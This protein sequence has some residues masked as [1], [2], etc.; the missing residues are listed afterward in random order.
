MA[1]ESR[2]GVII[3]PEQRVDAYTALQA[4]T[5]G[6]AYQFFEENR[7]GKIKVGMLADFVILEKNPLKQAVSDIKNNEVVQTIKE[8]KTVY[9]KKEDNSRKKLAGSKRDSHGCIGSA[10]YSWCAKTNQCERPWEL[11]KIS[12]FENS[13]SAFN[14][15]CK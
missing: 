13:Q 14:S 5:T 9:S 10:G 8:G 4:L 15:Y 12:G 7:K 2:S 1:R 11:A 6:P 3:G